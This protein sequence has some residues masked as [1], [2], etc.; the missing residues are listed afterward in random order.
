MSFETD[1]PKGD[2]ENDAE[3]KAKGK[4]QEHR[5]PETGHTAAWPRMEGIASTPKNEGRWEGGI[6]RTA[7]T[8]TINLT[9]SDFKVAE[10]HRN[11]F[12]EGRVSNLKS[13]I[14]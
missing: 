6:P 12:V 13:N 7:E 1:Y 2:R 11:F 5:G 9:Y 14:V 10:D 8:N 3:R 4:V